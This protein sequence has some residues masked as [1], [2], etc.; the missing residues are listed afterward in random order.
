MHVIE[1]NGYTLLDMLSDIGGILGILKS[2]FSLILG[3]INYDF[4]NDTLVSKLYKLSYEENSMVKKT[5][6]INTGTEYNTDQ[7]DSG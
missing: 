6:V 2:L 3:V 5:Q 7:S 4:L 1:R